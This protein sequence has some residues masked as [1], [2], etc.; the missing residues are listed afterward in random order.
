MRVAERLA[1]IGDL[2]GLPQQPHALAI[3]RQGRDLTIRGR[4]SQR[5]LVVGIAG[6]K[7]HRQRRR[8]V[9]TRQQPARRREIEIGIAPLERV[10]RRKAVLFDR[11]DRLRL[12][13]PDVAP[14]DTRGRPE[15]AV[16]HMA[17]GAAGDLAEFGRRQPPHAAAVELGELGKGHMVDVHV[18]AHADRIGGDEVIDLARLIHGHL[19]VARPGA[20][21]AEHNRGPAALTAHQLGH[22]VDFGRGERH[23]RR[24]PRQTRDLLRAGPAQGREPRPGD[25]LDIRHEGADQ[26]F[27]GFG[28]EKHR[29]RVAAGVQQPVGEHVA[30]LAV[31]AH[32]NLVD[33]EERDVAVE[34]HRLDRAHKPARI[35]RHDP[36]FPGHQ[37]DALATLQANDTVVILAGKKTQRK[38]DHAAAMAEHAFEGKM[39]LAGIRRPEHRDHAAA[40]FPA[41]SVNSRGLTHRAH[42]LP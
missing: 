36:L 30:A 5:E 40:G 3:R 10:Q 19:G 38:A 22:A 8:G 20:E 2:A 14:V 23:G 11:R 4:R 7:E 6:P 34:R 9:E 25:K 27:G 41:T 32:L 31:G 33:G 42:C 35:R 24:P 28:A 17:A 1:E 26:A 21:G 39:G 18:E 29:L 16:V 15:R 12:Q 37:S 13:R